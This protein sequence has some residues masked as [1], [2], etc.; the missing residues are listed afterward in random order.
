[1]KM[2]N[3]S[4]IGILVLFSFA[5][6][7]SMVSAVAD[8]VGDYNE[9]T[10]TIL[11][12]DSAN[13]ATYTSPEVTFTLTKTIEYDLITDQNYTD[14]VQYCKID[15]SQMGYINNTIDK[16]EYILTK[17]FTN[18]DKNSFLICY[19]ASNEII[20]NK[21]ISFNVDYTA[22][23]T[24]ANLDRINIDPYSNYNLANDIDC[25]SYSM[26]I[27]TYYGI[28]DGKGYNISNYYGASSL[29]SILYGTIKNLQMQNLSI[30][31]GGS[32]GGLVSQ[33]GSTVI[34][35]SVIDNVKVYGKIVAT[36]SNV[37]GIV[38]QNWGIIKNSE[39]NMDINS[40][41]QRVGGIVGYNNANIE[42]GKIENCISK[43][44]VSAIAKTGGL[45][46]Y[47]IGIINNSYAYNEVSSSGDY[48]GGLVGYNNGKVIKS[49]SDLK[50]KG[51]EYVG[52]LIGQNGESYLSS[53]QLEFSYALGN[54]TCVGTNITSGG[55][56]GKNYA[57]IKDVYYTKT[58]NTP[59]N[60]IGNNVAINTNQSDCRTSATTAS[61]NI[62]INGSNNFTGYTGYFDFLIID[63]K[64][65]PIMEFNYNIVNG[66][67]TFNET[68][69]I[70]GIASKAAGYLIINGMNTSNMG[71]TKTI[72]LERK[73]ITMT[74]VCI[75]DQE[76]NASDEI[77]IK[78]DGKDE[79]IVKCDAKNYF[80]Y[81]CSLTS[82]GTHY[83]ISGLKHS[84]V[85]QTDAVEDTSSDGGSSGGS[86]GGSSGSSSGCLKNYSCSSWSTCYSNGTGNMQVRTCTQVAPLTCYGGT[87]PVERQTCTIVKKD[88]NNLVT[89]I[90]S[91]DAAENDESD[92]IDD[93]QSTALL[94]LGGIIL[95][96]IVYFI[97]NKISEYE[98]SKIPLKKSPS[99]KS[100]KK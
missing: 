74:D 52:G 100:K 65:K 15:G 24:C 10:L 55:A 21:S 91:V 59:E 31:G 33:S 27:S 26:T 22:I 58:A 90:G 14:Q 71:G 76:I 75:K 56:I 93:N 29:F 48:V 46:G 50:V 69:V 30:N 36:A 28:F 67:L 3:Y 66:S 83:K 9:T 32:I 2:S 49:I 94:I 84:G 40:S 98:A 72:Y 77:G 70:N 23:K 89:R 44:K 12:P 87:K 60:C 97:F 88:T 7:L 11:N 79:Y 20:Y 51:K 57:K 37:G 16:G 1:M 62:T 95:F 43:S 64:L 17:N 86:G 42:S 78:C 99:I 85:I 18:G 53:P 73:N 4:L 47:N 19:N 39:T 61:L 13:P 34:S 35:T 68:L 96:I 80:G 92:N 5:Y 6:S 25:S 38:A 45:A 54:V 81:N 63:D 41:S 8:I 82:D